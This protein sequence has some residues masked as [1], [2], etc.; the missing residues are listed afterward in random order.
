[1][2]GHQRRSAFVLHQEHEEFRRFG[3]ACISPN[4][5]NII[6]A[7]IEAL[8]G[9]QSRFLSASHLHHDRA[10]QHIN[11]PMCI[12]AMYG[13]RT[14]WRYS[15]VSMRPSLPGMSVR[16]FDK[17]CVTLGSWATS[18]PVARHAS[19]KISFVDVLN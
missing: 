16:S 15:T 12:V 14:A 13:V 11:K 5:V 8:T 18:A 4:D 19:T 2:G 7:F 9:C 1:M 17:T 10:F 3:L 6:G